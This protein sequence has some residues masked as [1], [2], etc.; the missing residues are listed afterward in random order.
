MIE[1]EFAGPGQHGGPGEAREEIR[2]RK[3]GIVSVFIC[4]IFGLLSQYLHGQTSASV[5]E[6]LVQDA[7]GAL[8]QS[9]DVTLL[10]AE[11]GGKLAT[12]ANEAGVYVFSSVQP[13]LYA[14]QVL[15]AGFKSY[16][17]TN[18][19][20]RPLSARDRMLSLTLAVPQQQ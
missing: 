17:V 6:G 10:N 5:V 7:T 16:S 18:F 3:L 11:N 12:R 20:V 2:M 14:L 1:V 15:K 13:G 19:R 8:I 4:F 9:C